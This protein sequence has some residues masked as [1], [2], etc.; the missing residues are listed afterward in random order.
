MQK[1]LLPPAPVVQLGNQRQN[2]LAK[3]KFHAAAGS[4]GSYRATAPEHVGGILIEQGASIWR[5]YH[6]LAD[7]AELLPPLD[8]QRQRDAF[9]TGRRQLRCSKNS[10]QP[11]QAVD[12][13]D[14][15]VEG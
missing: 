12:V 11:E 13:G 5:R 8:C 4:V 14:A 6:R 2:S 9:Q 3:Q 7:L 15:S 10:T 1:V